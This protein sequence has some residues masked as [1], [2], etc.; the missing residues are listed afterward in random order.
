MN[1]RRE[2]L[3][4]LFD[5]LA[6]LVPSV[7]DVDVKDFKTNA[8]DGWEVTCRWITKVRSSFLGGIAE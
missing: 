1:G 6:S 4:G 8:E 2:M 3:D 7:K 5:A